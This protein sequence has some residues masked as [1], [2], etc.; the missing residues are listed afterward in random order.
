MG[1]VRWQ[2]G[3]KM[4]HEDIL[5]R[6]RYNTNEI[7]TLNERAWE[8]EPSSKP[9]TDCI[10]TL[11]DAIDNPRISA[12][13]KIHAG[14]QEFDAW[15]KE[16][17]D[18]PWYLWHTGGGCMVALVDVKL[19]NGK[20]VSLG[21]NAECVCLYNY[22]WLKDQEPEYRDEVRWDWQRK[23]NPTVLMNYLENHVSDKESHAALFDEIMSVMNSEFV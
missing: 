11:L 13:D 8:F 2:K 16:K 18:G 22:S 5:A 4:N 3:L 1:I 17:L 10:R 19:L 12:A 23:D 15:V 20:S 6:I 14:Y 9:L 21:V 7:I